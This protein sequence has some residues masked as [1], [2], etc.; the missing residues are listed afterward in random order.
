MFVM[1]TF[2]SIGAVVLCLSLLGLACRHRPD[3]WIVAD[4]TILCFVAPALI[5]LSAFGA[6]SLGWR[7]THGGFWEVS[8]GAWTGSAVI[9][10]LLVGIWYVAA[11][12]IRA[13]SRKPAA[14]AA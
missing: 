4:D 11:A 5:A 12:R 14:A 1:F 8:G 2:A 3:L 10:A 13:T 6:L 9:A 7:I